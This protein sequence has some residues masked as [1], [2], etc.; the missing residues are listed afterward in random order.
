MSLSK[1][2][3]ATSSVRPVLCPSG[4]IANTDVC[5][6]PEN[7]EV[8]S[9]CEAYRTALEKRDAAALL[10]LTSR[11]YF[12]DGGNDDP[13]DDIGRAELETYLSDQFKNVQE[14][15]YELRYRKITPGPTI[16]VDVTH[17]ASFRFGTE[18]KRSVS[19]NTIELKREDGKLLI[20]GGM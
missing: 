18:W 10:A 6:T 1:P 17:S 16:R 7:R 11:D 2:A 5:D 20:L 19:D 14:I 8:L 3:A 15:R 12:E 9:V 13:S 4:A